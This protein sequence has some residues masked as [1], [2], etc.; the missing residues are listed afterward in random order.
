M[1]TSNK[2]SSVA[3]FQRFI[4]ICVVS[5]L[6][7]SC[8]YLDNPQP[9]G[10]LPI[11]T[12]FR[13]AED[14]EDALVGAYDAVQNGHLLGRN[15]VVF[16]DLIGEN[17]S[18]SG[19][20]WFGLSEIANHQISTTSWYVEN[21]WV[22]AYKAINQLNMLLRS[23]PEVKQ[24]D[25]LFTE[26]AC[27]RIEG[28]AAFLR[29]VLYFEIV[30]LFGLPWDEPF[31]DSLG[32]PLQLTPVLKKEELRFPARATIGEVYQQVISDLDLAIQLLENHP[33]H[34]RAS[35]FAALAYRARVAFQQ[36]DDEKV[37]ALTLELVENSPFSLTETPG[38]FFSEKRNKEQIWS[39]LNDPGDGITGENMF[40]MFD[41][42]DIQPGLRGDYASIVTPAQQGKISAAGYR[43]VDL[44]SD[45][46]GI[47]GYPFV[48][49]DT[50][51]ITKFTAD[52][53]APAARLAEFILMR[54]EVL[55]QKNDFNEAVALLNRIRK[56]SLRILDSN[57]Y[58]VQEAEKDFVL[59]EPGELTKAELLEAIIRERRVELAFEG[60]YFHDLMRLRE[61][62]NDYL[63]YDAP[64]LRFPVPQREMDVNPFLIQNPG[65]Q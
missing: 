6:V 1:K 21:T 29:G 8:N 3:S 26:A 39:I 59:F 15:L 34:G 49:G 50:S 51:A 5:L 37:D 13:T 48:S 61:P 54:A 17:A 30:R 20:G 9:T 41:A 43:A 38:K 33:P 53:D 45:T 65:Y 19:S 55:G 57:G 32:I 56:R 36:R 62:V 40:S 52:A 23:L 64:E 58:L 4:P 60:N 16:P 47:S 14:L 10:A 27:R 31:L 22:Q 46:L 12:S 42:A 2:A 44:R 63:L 35:R 18:Y 25:K 11:D 24:Q 7:V 28:E